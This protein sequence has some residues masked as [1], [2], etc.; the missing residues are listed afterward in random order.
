MFRAILAAGL[1]TAAAPATAAVNLIVNGGFETG[2]F[3]GWTRTGPLARE[4]SRVV[5][6]A[7]LDGVWGARFSANTPYAGISQTFATPDYAL[8]RYIISFA[9]RHSAGKARFPQYGFQISLLYPGGPY[10]GDSLAEYHN[11]FAGNY[12]FTDWQHASFTVRLAAPVTTLSFGYFDIY[13]TA[14]DLDSISVTEV[15]FHAAVPEPDLWA[16]LIAGF[17]LTGV[18]FRRRR[19]RSAAA[20]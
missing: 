20:A 8:T 19:A 18:G 11:R 15:P 10:G 4:A 16:M 7:A 14:W 6:P 1:L 9:F 17:G 3:A 5:R 12:D 2:T 13:S